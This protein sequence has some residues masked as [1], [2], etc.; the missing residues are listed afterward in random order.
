VSR[1]RARLHVEDVRPLCLCHV[2][3]G[4]VFLAYEQ[5]RGAEK[6]QVALNGRT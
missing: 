2:G 3:V 1:A 5:P 4:L 6:A